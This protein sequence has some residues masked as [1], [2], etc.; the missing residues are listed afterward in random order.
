M[1]LF[2][3]C[4]LIRKHVFSTF[5]PAVLNYKTYI[6]I[7]FLLRFK[8]Y[9][10][11][12]VIMN[13]KKLDLCL[14]LASFWILNVCQIVFSRLNVLLKIDGFCRLNESWMKYIKV[15]LL[16]L[17]S[18]IL[19]QIHDYFWS[20]VLYDFYPTVQHLFCT[21]RRTFTSTVLVLVPCWRMLQ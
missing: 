19:M 18:Y 20:T 14:L 6:N 13:G 11:W 10:R 15:L 16:I 9:H 8:L 12:L 21:V 3:I 7:L 2:Y 1:N 17:I 4:I 5:W